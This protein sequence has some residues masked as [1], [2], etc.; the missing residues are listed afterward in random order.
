MDVSRAMHI[1]RIYSVALRRHRDWDALSEGC[2]PPKSE[3]P[4]KPW[5]PTAATMHELGA[6]ACHP[7]TSRSFYPLTCTY[8]LLSFSFFSAKMKLNKCLDLLIL[9]ALGMSNHFFSQKDCTL[10]LASLF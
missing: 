8:P 5:I 4:I 6:K 10:E 2:S 9:A 3:M 1:V 7:R